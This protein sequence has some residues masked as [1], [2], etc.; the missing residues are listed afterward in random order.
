MTNQD[1]EELKAQN[2][3]YLFLKG[4]VYKIE[5]SRKGYETL[6]ET[7]TADLKVTSYSFTLKSLM[8]SDADLKYLYVSS[9]DHY[10]KG[11]QKLEPSFKKTED[12]YTAV[13]GDERQSL[14]VWT[15]AADSHGSIKVYAMS[16]ILGSSVQKDE[17]IFQTGTD[18]GH[19][20]WKIVF[21]SGEKEAKIRIQVTAEDGT[22]KNVY[23]TLR[24]T[25]KT[26]PVLKKVS[27]S[28]IST[29]KASVVYKTSEKGYRY[30]KVV[31]A[32][33][34]IP[35]VDTSGKGTE[36]QAGTDTITLTGLTSGEKDLVVVVKDGS[37][38]VSQ[39]L[40]IRIPDIK[41]AG[42]GTGNNGNNSSVIHRPGS[43][44]HKS[45]AGRPGSGSDG[46]GSKAN[47][48]K[49]NGTGS[50]GQAGDK[51]GTSTDQKKTGSKGKEK[52][53]G[54]SED[55]KKTAEKNSE[56]SG[57]SSGKKAE[58]TNGSSSSDTGS[59]GDSLES[60]GNQEGQT[61][62]AQLADDWKGMGNFSKLLIILAVLIAGYLSFWYRARKYYRKKLLTSRRKPYAAT[63]RYR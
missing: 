8:S 34:K 56:T 42:S 54:K 58:T 59:D 52:D 11:I 23:L 37:G 1:G 51:N 60:T 44:G 61:V 46:N 3:K 30:Y 41:N 43:G 40:V 31:D 20:F 63:K 22:R 27:A 9:A 45:E 28:R 4:N 2:G 62:T 29:D 17:T 53:T 49:V 57:K 16:G 26:A 19:P 35:A 15:E 50:G 12:H 7:V 24:L 39:Q 32:G 55:K 13:Y 38:N 18:E 14:N 33:K 21:A 47:L 5:I 48:K 25:D 36:V 10:G 6:T